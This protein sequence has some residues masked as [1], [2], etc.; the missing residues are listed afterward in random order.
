MDTLPPSNSQ[1]H[2]YTLNSL[3]TGQYGHGTNGALP[4]D[5]QSDRNAGFEGCPVEAFPLRTSEGSVLNNNDI[6]SGSVNGAQHQFEL[7]QQQSEAPRTTLCGPRIRK[8]KRD[9]NWTKEETSV[10]V[11]L[12]EEATREKG[13]RFCKGK[14][15]ATN[16]DAISAEMQ[17]KLG[18]TTSAKTGDQCRLRWDT[19]MKSY[20]KIALHCKK[21]KKKFSEL[22]EEERGEL[23][24]ATT[25]SE[26]R[27]YQVIDQFCRPKPRKARAQKRE[28]FERGVG[29]GRCSA[30]PQDSSSETR[31]ICEPRKS[32]CRKQVAIPGFSTLSNDR[33][34]T[35]LDLVNGSIILADVPWVSLLLK[36]A[37]TCQWISILQNRSPSKISWDV[38]SL[39]KKKLVYKE[40]AEDGKVHLNFDRLRVYVKFAW[41]VASKNPD[42]DTYRRIWDHKSLSSF[43]S[44]SMPHRITTLTLGNCLQL[45][46]ADLSNSPKLRCLVITGCIKLQVVTGWEH[47]QELGWLTIQECPSY[48]NLPTVQCL[49]SLKNYFIS[50]VEFNDQLP[51]SLEPE[52][53]Q[54]VRPSRLVPEVRQFV[55]LCRLELYKNKQLKESGDLSSLKCLQVLRF[56]QCNALTTIRGLSGLHSLT[57]LD[58]SF[59]CA[60]SWLP[61]VANMKAL[62]VLD[63]FA[64]PMEE[65][66]GIEDLVSLEKL[67]CTKSNLKRLPDLYH[68]PQLQRIRLLETPLVKDPSSVY[69]GKD[70]VELYGDEERRM[71]YVDVSDISDSEHT[72]TEYCET[73]YS[74]DSDL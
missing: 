48:H 33:R 60:L 54:I 23:K 21:S 69:F 57:T 28:G 6:G 7:N 34:S 50:L 70:L 72:H 71:E 38:C 64:T 66:I 73:L 4:V 16:W 53:T 43:E 63:I 11:D 8:R 9:S 14:P 3:S 15:T 18:T 30:S 52:V 39:V 74:S 5:F 56:R 36:V 41:K 31:H 1:D 26:D 17:N 62:T 2:L 42:F 58:L 13:S 61:S 51:W 65:I 27:W 49:P 25:L 44:L 35:L 59:C 32:Y 37:D 67:D 29:N 10:L 40:S 24:L 19:L 55:R 47:L 46:E 45:V 20:Q 12:K 22:T 68:L